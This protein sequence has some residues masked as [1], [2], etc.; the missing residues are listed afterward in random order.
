[1]GQVVPSTIVCEW[2][3]ALFLDS[4][5]GRKV[6]GTIAA[7]VNPPPPVN[8]NPLVGQSFVS[9]IF[10]NTLNDSLL[11]E[12][13][14][15]SGFSL[16][17]MEQNPYYDFYD[18]IEER[19]CDLLVEVLN[20]FIRLSLDLCWSESSCPLHHCISFYSHS[21]SQ[22]IVN[23]QKLIQSNSMVDF[24]GVN[25]STYILELTP[26]AYEIRQLF[27]DPFSGIFFKG[28]FHSLYSLFIV[29]VQ[30]FWIK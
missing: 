7:V 11:K 4:W 18:V 20:A 24:T 2:F 17:F 27:I 12:F 13:G 29:T 30:E 6:V 19:M 1:M 5:K 22:V 21:L 28:I 15:S 14:L 26:S 9:D 16:G 25:P 10:M 23:S 3:R 8:F